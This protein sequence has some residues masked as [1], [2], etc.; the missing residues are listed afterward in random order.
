VAGDDVWLTSD[1]RDAVVRCGLDGSDLEVAW[2]EERSLNDRLKREQRRVGE[3]V[4][5]A[6]G[7]AWI[8]LEVYRRRYTIVR[9]EERWLGP[10]GSR[11]VGWT[12]LLDCHQPEFGFLMPFDQ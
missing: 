8:L 6:A 7:S 11:G 3:I 10:L 4:P 9:R 2:T 5:V 1:P 12:P